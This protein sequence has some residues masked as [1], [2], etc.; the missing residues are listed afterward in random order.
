MTLEIVIRF[1]LHIV[2]EQQGSLSGGLTARYFNST[3]RPVQQIKAG[4]QTTRLA[5]QIELNLQRYL[6]L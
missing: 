5:S 1:T 2:N 3:F 4:T 6:Y